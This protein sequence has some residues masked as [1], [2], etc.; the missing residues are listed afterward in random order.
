[1]PRYSNEELLTA[2]EELADDVG[3][4]PKAAEVRSNDDTASEVTYQNRFGSWNE[5]LEAAGLDPQSRNNIPDDELLDGL[6]EFVRFLGF[7]PTK[8]KMDREGPFHSDAYERAFGDW[9]SAVSELGLS[10]PDGTQISDRELIDALREFANYYGRGVVKVPTKWD[11][12]ADGPH[13]HKIYWERFGSWAKAL[14]EAGLNPE[15]R[16]SRETL[17]D[18]LRRVAAD[19][20]APPTLAEY[21]SHGSFSTSVFYYRFESFLMALEEAGLNPGDRGPHRQLGDVEHSDAD[22]LRELTRVAGS[23]HRGPTQ[24]EFNA[25]SSMSSDTVIKRFGSWVRALQLASLIPPQGARTGVARGGTSTVDIARTPGTLD[26]PRLDELTITA[27]EVDYLIR[28]GDHLFDN[29]TELEYEVVD[30]RVETRALMPQWIVEGR[31]L[32]VEEPLTRRFFHDELSEW[33]DTPHLF[34]LSTDR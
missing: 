27:D 26:S 28:P 16:E 30:L 10:P 24:A 14:V 19:R 18:D 15:R 29:R 25:A 22:L 1:M 20:G 9:E 31:L 32:A 2:L 3:R 34:V 8:S 13:S 7:V 17:L 11:L 4:P 21:Q 6:V 23:D 12:D 33:L 5:A